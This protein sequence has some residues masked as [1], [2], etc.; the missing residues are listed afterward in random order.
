M[1]ETEIRKYADL[2]QELGLTGLEI[3]R[4]D[5][6]VRLERTPGPAL[7]VPEKRSAS[8]EQ[9]T[10]E[11]SSAVFSP[12][13]GV[14]YAAATENADP[15]VTVG[16]HVKKGQTLCMIEAMKMFNEITAEK[17]GVITEVCVKNGQMVEYGTPLFRIGS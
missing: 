9:Q 3:T 4:N 2:M 13:V 15:Y 10:A 7:P 17:E 1:N 14:F 11:D 6:V 12:L 16:D 5:Q 8:C